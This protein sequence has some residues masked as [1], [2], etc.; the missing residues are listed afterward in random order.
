MTKTE[1]IQLR[2][3][4]L[5]DQRSLTVHRFG[6]P[7]A[8]PKVYVQAGTHA[9]ELAAPMTAHHLVCRLQEAEAAG[10]I[11]G[12]IIVVPVANPIGLSQI[13]SGDHLGRHDLE[14]GSNFNRDFF[15]TSDAVRD[16][17]GQAD[18]RCR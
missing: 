11:M 17:C 10:Q 7:G 3:V 4:S 18:A 9:T 8:R 13:Q 15:D 16:R 6:E 2:Q 12:E 1:Q 14:T 5:N